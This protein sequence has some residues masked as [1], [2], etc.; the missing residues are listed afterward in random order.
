[1]TE[2]E[3]AFYRLRRREELRRAET[4]T[5]MAAKQ[6]HLEWARYFA[7]RLD[8][9]RPPKPNAPYVGPASLSD[10]AA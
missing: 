10:L 3:I 9:Q 4:V 7:T 1:M 2:G 8:G 6:V 5:D